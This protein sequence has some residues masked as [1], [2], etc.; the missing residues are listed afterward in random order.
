MISVFPVTV[1]LWL[2]GRHPLKVAA[3]L[4]VFRRLLTHSCQTLKT[5]FSVVSCKIQEYKV[6]LLNLQS[7]LNR[8]VVL[9]LCSVWHP[10]RLSLFTPGLPV[11]EKDWTRLASRKSCAVK[12]RGIVGFF[13]KK[14]DKSHRRGFTTVRRK[15]MMSRESSAS[16]QQ[17]NLLPDTLQCNVRAY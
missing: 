13:I 15:T 11:C 3:T 14:T 5:S 16:S 9:G 2:S 12:S 4:N 7:P 8:A 10:Q 6:L 1:A 17:K